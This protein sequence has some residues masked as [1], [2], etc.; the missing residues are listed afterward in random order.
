MGALD[1]HLKLFRGKT[2]LHVHFVTSGA[3]F[4]ESAFG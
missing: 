1:C 2:H 4:A 3:Q